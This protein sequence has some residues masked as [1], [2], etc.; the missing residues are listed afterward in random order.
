MITEPIVTYEEAVQR[1]QFL[2]LLPLA[3]LFPDFPSLSSLTP[4]ENWHTD[5]DLDP[6]LWRSRLAEDGVAAY[7]KFVKKKA[8]LISR[9]YFPWV[10]RLLSD[11]RTIQEQYDAGLLSRDAFKLYERIEEQE[12]IDGRA[13]RTQA[14]FGAK[15]DKKAFDQGL[16][17]LQSSTAIVISG[18]K[19]KEGLAEG[20][21][22]WNS[23]SYETAGHW[24]SRQGI[25]RFEG[26]IP[27]ARDL[28]LEK[29][30]ENTT[31]A[32][33]VKIK[34]AFGMV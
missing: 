27:E 25:E 30:K 4:R 23:S 5:T 1:I 7:G 26:S 12:G 21:V 3:P 24:M 16:L 32:G 17:D 2:G 11:S 31:G 14:G 20:K 22:A 19:E 29:L 8:L 28:L 18:T 6:W 10:H 34:K 33:L 9:E 13:L 15:E